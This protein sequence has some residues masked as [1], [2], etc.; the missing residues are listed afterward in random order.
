[1]SVIKAGAHVQLCV[2]MQSDT[3]AELGSYVSVAGRV[4]SDLRCECLNIQ[5]CA[6]IC[7]LAINVSTCS[8]ICAGTASSCIVLHASCCIK[9]GPDMA[10]PSIWLCVLPAWRHTNIVN[11]NFAPVA[12]VPHETNAI[13]H[14]APAR[15]YWFSSCDIMCYPKLLSHIEL[16]WTDLKQTLPTLPSNVLPLLLPALNGRI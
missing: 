4:G 16:Q 3:W 12:P 13:V 10:L 7:W 6:C 14:Q 8:N 9:H 2:V 11:A 5:L 1:M 15:Q